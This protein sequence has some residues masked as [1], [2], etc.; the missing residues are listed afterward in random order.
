VFGTQFQRI[1]DYFDSFDLQSNLVRQC[2]AFKQDDSKNGVVRRVLFSKRG[3]NANVLVKANKKASSDNLVYEYAAGL[4]LN[5]Y[6][7]ILPCFVQT[8]GIYQFTNETY[9]RAFIESRLHASKFAQAFAPLQTPFELTCESNHALV[10]HFLEGSFPFRQLFDE[11]SYLIPNLFGILY[12]VY[13]GLNALRR[14]FTHYDLHMQNV[15]LY[16]LPGPILFRYTNEF[17]TVQFKCQYLA[18]IIDYG[19]I[20]FEGEMPSKE[21]HQRAID[22]NC[23]SDV[24][25]GTIYPM[26]NESQGLRLMFLVREKLKGNMARFV[27]REEM[28]F[29]K[30]VVFTG[31]FQTPERMDCPDLICTVHG[32]L[33]QMHARRD[34]NRYD[35][36]IGPE[37]G[38]LVVDGVSPVVFKKSSHFTPRTPQ[39]IKSSTTSPM[40]GSA[41]VKDS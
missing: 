10:T 4:F 17:G 19:R 5:P 1:V 36:A 39:R 11:P 13:Y 23:A 8:H 9:R 14:S 12:Q 30:R 20:Y 38:T 34:M 35:S 16:A 29:Y 22:A 3:Y 25:F 26:N 40:T 31:K 7:S 18:K 27:L 15:L 32:L 6:C 24:G 33:Q 41:T 21:F 37:Y 2:W 28:A